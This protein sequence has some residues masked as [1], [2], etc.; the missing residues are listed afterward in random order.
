M[1]GCVDGTCSNEILKTPDSEFSDGL[2]LMTDI[3]NV[4]DYLSC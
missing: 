2:R 3:S 4:F 1:I